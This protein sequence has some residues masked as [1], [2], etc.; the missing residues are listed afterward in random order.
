MGAL[1]RDGAA[2]TDWIARRNSE[3]LAAGSRVTQ[4]QA[5]AQQ[6]R[7]LLPNPQIDASVSSLPL[8]PT[9]PAG[10]SVNE[11]SS[12][13]VGLSQTIEIGKRGLRI[14]AAELR[15]EEAKNGYLGSTADKVAD[16]RYALARVA[17][18]KGRLALLEENLAGAQRVA[19][20][21]R[22][23][24]EHG[25]LSGNDYDR[26]LLDTIT[27]TSDVAR[28]RAEYTAALGVCQAVLH[29]PCDA[30]AAEPSDLDTAAP[31]P[32][33]PAPFDPARRPDI[34]ALRLEGKAAEKDAELARRQ[35]IPDPTVRLAYTRDNSAYLPSGSQPNTLSLTV[36]VPLPIFDHGQYAA[37]RA[38]ARAEEQRHLADALVIG[39]ETGVSALWTRKAS[40][41]AALATLGAQAVPKSK[42]VLDSTSKAFDQGQ[43]SMTDLLLARRTHLALVLS[44]MDLRFDFF[45]VRNDLRRAL[46]LDVSASPPEKAR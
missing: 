17:Y 30:D 4:A 37:A 26:L 3:L 40:V 33:V 22:A 36:S 2:L 27:L 9:I 43:V 21:E 8:G 10:R 18:L 13:N 34:E 35:A 42:G 25:A 28:N 5:D 41:E 19:D 20:L 6:S 15:V 29:A 45:S 46:G 23:R 38:T 39:G 16:A 1:L 32:A 7:V 14:E 12:Y 11:V 44:E 24:L 31:I